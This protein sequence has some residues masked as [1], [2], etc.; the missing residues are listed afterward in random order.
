MSVVIRIMEEVESD[1]AKIREMTVQTQQCMLSW[2]GQYRYQ[3]GQV[4]MP[5]C[6]LPL[7]LCGSQVLPWQV[8]CC[9]AQEALLYLSPCTQAAPVVWKSSC[10]AQV[11]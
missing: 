7:K 9:R 10:P 11:F 4:M 6:C 3:Y 1:R 5:G 2:E 8:W